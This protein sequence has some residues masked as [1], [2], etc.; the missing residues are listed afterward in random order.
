MAADSRHSLNGFSVRLQSMSV[1][2]ELLSRNLPGEESISS[3]TQIVGRNIFFV[4]VGLRLW[5]LF[6]SWL[7]A[8][9][10]F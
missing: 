2:T 10:H 7:S 5:L 1:R 8:G 3:V 9:G 6:G 4:V